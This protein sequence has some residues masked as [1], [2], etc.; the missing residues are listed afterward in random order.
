M[1]ILKSLNS[2]LIENFFTVF[3]DLVA[4]QRE[5]KLDLPEAELGCTGGAICTPKLVHDMQSFL[6]IKKVQAVYGLTETSAVVFQTNSTDDIANVQ[7]FVGQ[8]SDNTEAKVVDK[9]GNAVPF[10]QPGELCIRGYCTMLG[11]WNDEEKTRECLSRDNW[12]KTG[13][14][15][16][17]Y[18]N[19][20]G[21]IIG[22]FKEMISR[23]G[24]NIFPREIE[25]FLNTHPNILENHVIGIPEERWG[26]EV[27]AFVRLKN[28]TK[29]L[30]RKDV[31]DFCKGK[32]SHFK[33]P[34]HVVIVNEFPRTLSGKIQKFKFLDVFQEEFKASLSDNK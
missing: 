5:L 24:E 14:Q 20:Y 27:G 28:N 25:D 29:P 12:F 7:E 31:K 11:Y 30:T 17:L 16:I 21:K 22:R 9:D 8:V 18:E 13:D 6:R 23:G 10:G 34:R 3:V 1:R 19:G 2:Q 4:K 32:L 33:I 26:E 15:F